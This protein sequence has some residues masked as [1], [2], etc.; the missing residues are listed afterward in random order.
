[1]DHAYDRTDKKR[2]L[3][4]ISKNSQRGRFLVTSDYRQIVEEDLK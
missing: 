2:F 1:M 4:T 3:E